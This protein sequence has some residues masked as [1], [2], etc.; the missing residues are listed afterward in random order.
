MQPPNTRLLKSNTV[1]TSI[2]KRYLRISHVAAHT[3]IGLAIASCIFPFINKSRKARLI[4][5]W[6]KQLLTAFNLRVT[7]FGHVPEANATFTNTL[8][9]ANHISWADIH[10]LN[11]MLPLRF[12]AKSEIKNWPIFGYLVS[13]ANTLFVDRNNRRGARHTIE[14]AASSLKSGDN[15]CLFPEGTTTDGTT[16]RPFKSSLLQAA[17][18]AQ[19]TVWPIAIRYP[20]P[21]GEINTDVAYAGETT[22]VESMRKVLLQT[23]P[24]VEL[25]F[26]APMTPVE[27][28]QLDRRALSLH[29]EKLIR[30]RIAPT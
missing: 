10:A 13:H 9:I 16:I 8:F 18:Q 5:W 6:C 2:F 22:L 4:S 12:I 20:L 14:V 29:I 11:S 25:H 15:L 19:T 7:C 30:E 1:S 24:V 28:S 27:Y 26:L 17:Y 21:N 23:Q 3:L